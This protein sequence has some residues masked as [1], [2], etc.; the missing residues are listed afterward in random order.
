MN[1][2]LILSE[3]ELYGLVASKSCDIPAPLLRLFDEMGVNLNKNRDIV[4]T[5]QEKR[6]AQ[7]DGNSLK[8]EP[9][10][11]LI[12]DEAMA[13]QSIHTAKADVY[14][15]ECPSMCLLISRYEWA[16]GTWRIAPF[17]DMH[18]LLSSLTD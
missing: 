9:L 16:A 7:W 15:V 10:L 14:A 8:I 1:T 6:L 3:D 13:A 11:N 12:I 5:L 18:A 2:A 17:Q 4:S